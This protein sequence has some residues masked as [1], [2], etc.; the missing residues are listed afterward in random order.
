MSFSDRQAGVSLKDRV[1]SSVT[2]ERHGV[3]PLLLRLERSQ[4]VG[5]LVQ[6]P[7]E[8]LLRKVLYAL[9]TG[10]RPRGRPKT[11]RRKY[12]TSPTPAEDRLGIPIEEVDDQDREHWKSLLELLPRPDSG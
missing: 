12:C 5:H 3:E 6:M 8:H 10:R 1:R 4:V 9:P 7:L 2:R 11:R